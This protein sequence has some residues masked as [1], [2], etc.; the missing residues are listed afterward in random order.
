[1]RNILKETAYKEVPK[2]KRNK[3]SKWLSD[4]ALQIAQ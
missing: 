4:E 1:M 2:I 3:V